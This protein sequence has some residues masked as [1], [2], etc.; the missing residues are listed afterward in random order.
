MSAGVV[1]PYMDEDW[2]VMRNKL[3][4]SVGFL[5]DAVKASTT[6]DVRAQTG[7]AM[8][9]LLDAIFMLGR[10]ERATDHTNGSHD[11]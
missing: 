5:Q 4:L 9:Q 8:A 11:A 2:R 6:E 3:N 10:I 1:P 7:L